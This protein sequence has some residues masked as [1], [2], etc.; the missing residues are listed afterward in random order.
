MAWAAVSPEMVQS[1]E[2]ALRRRRL[3]EIRCWSE[4]V[5]R[6]HAV[7]AAA[8][9]GSAPSPSGDVVAQVVDAGHNDMQRTENSSRPV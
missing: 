1:A 6:G 5:E 3:D 8:D 4:P 7:E 2:S 9:Q